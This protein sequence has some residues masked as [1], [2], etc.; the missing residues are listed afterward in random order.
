MPRFCSLQGL[1]WLSNGYNEA[2][3]ALQAAASEAVYAPSEAQFLGRGYRH[4]ILQAQL[5]DKDL[6]VKYLRAQ[7][8]SA[9]QAS[10]LKE[11]SIKAAENLI[12]WLREREEAAKQGRSKAQLAL[13]EKASALQSCQVQTETLLAE[14]TQCDKAL[15]H[16][17]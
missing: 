7:L 3:A 4:R 15:R 8:E 11:D 12:R 13:A 1:R 9:V 16:G 10:K 5:R 2:D 6:E 17:L 14:V